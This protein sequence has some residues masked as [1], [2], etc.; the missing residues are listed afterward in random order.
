M[1]KHENPNI[2]VINKN[3][4]AV[5][6]SLIPFIP[7][8]SYKPDPSVPLEQVPGQ[9]GPDGIMILN[10]DFKHFELVK[11]ATEAVMKLK[12]RQIEKE[13]DS[14]HRFPT[15]QPLPL[16][17]NSVKGSLI[18]FPGPSTL[19]EWMPS[20]LATPLMVSMPT[21]GTRRGTPPL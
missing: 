8:I 10:K 4:W 15:N 13:L 14:L 1:L 2:E 20:I 19:M 17:T 9:F 5:R 16:A 3:L 18:K 12:N 21:P 7:Q 11:K 6:F